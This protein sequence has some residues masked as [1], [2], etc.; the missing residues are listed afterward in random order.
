[1]TAL[2]LCLCL[3]LGNA[4]TQHLWRIVRLNP[5]KVADLD[6]YFSMQKDPLALLH[7]RVL[8]K[9]PSLYAMAFLG[10]SIGLAVV[11]PPGALTVEGKLYHSV[12]TQSVGVFNAS[13]MGDGSLKNALDQSLLQ[14]GRLFIPPYLYS[15]IKGTLKTT[16]LTK[17]AKLNRL[18][19]LLLK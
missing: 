8:L 17:I 18:L 16:L 5:V 11:F 9:A 4:F 10:F 19:A 3:A 13:F 2:R 6:R 1:V 7:S 14:R 12:Q 15:P